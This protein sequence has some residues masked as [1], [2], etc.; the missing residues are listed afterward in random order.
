MNILNLFSKKKARSSRNRNRRRRVLGGES[1][2]GRAMM[3]ANLTVDSADPQL[4][5]AGR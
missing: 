4:P 1:L 5:S 3:A 2:E